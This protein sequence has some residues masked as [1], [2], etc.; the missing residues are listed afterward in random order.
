[1]K[2]PRSLRDLDVCRNSCREPLALRLL[3]C[4]VMFGTHRHIAI[5]TSSLQAETNIAQLPLG[6]GSIGG[7][8]NF[9]FAPLEALSKAFV[10]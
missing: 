1:M 5:I 10:V 3:F 9:F 2:Y 6:A 7:I 4:Y 8:A